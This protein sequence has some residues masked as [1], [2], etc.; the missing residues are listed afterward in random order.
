M[1][2]WAYRLDFYF[3]PDINIDIAIKNRVDSN[4]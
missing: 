2:N 4:N 1:I 3:L